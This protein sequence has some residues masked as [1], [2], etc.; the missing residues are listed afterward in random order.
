MY[1]IPPTRASSARFALEDVLFHQCFRNAPLRA[2]TA[3]VGRS[4]LEANQRIWVRSES[5]QPQRVR[6]LVRPSVQI[7]G[8]TR[9]FKKCELSA[10]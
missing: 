10:S 1:A 8:S 6:E 7:L 4:R 3:A 9:A 2:R 5:R